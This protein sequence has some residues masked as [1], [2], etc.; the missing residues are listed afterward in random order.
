MWA[1]FNNTNVHRDHQCANKKCLLTPS[2]S[3]VK[4]FGDI[5]VTY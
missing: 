3:P 5:L 1:H 4:S 2:P